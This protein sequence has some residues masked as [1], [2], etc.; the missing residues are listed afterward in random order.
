MQ[1]VDTACV[2]DNCMF[3]MSLIQ[4]CSLIIARRHCRPTR[5][6]AQEHVHTQRTHHM[7]FRHASHA[8]PNNS[9]PHLCAAHQP[10]RELLQLLGTL[11]CVFFH[12][13]LRP[14]QQPHA[15][16]GCTDTTRLHRS[17]TPILIIGQVWLHYASAIPIVSYKFS[18]AGEG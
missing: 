11:S 10:V 8:P 5:S 18:G 13:T 17:D 3:S 2:L 1:K 12:C 15:S 16:T 6:L 14:L 4:T 7:R 9:A